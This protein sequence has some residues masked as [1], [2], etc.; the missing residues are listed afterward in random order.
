MLV[1]ITKTDCSLPGA[2]Q[3]TCNF[4]HK[5]FNC[6]EVVKSSDLLAGL[7][8]QAMSR[9]MLEQTKQNIGQNKMSRT[10]NK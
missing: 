4:S 3:L 6:F 2:G 8:T 10:K 9:L 1:S 5:E 7:C